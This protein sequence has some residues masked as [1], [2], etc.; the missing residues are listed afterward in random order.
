MGK[1]NALNFVDNVRNNNCITCIHLIKYPHVYWCVKR[2]FTVEKF[3]TSLCD[4]WESDN[5]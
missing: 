2:K 1:E 5:E 4:S 3:V